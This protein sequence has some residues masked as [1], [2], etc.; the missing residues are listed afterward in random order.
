MLINGQF[1]NGEGNEEN[2]LNPVNAE[3]LVQIKE[4]A[5]NA[6]TENIYKLLS[7]IV[8]EFNPQSNSFDVI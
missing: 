5:L 1:V 2:I 7:Q 6:E 4:A 3:I 8:P